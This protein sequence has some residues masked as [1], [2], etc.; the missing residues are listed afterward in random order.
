MAYSIRF[1]TDM[2]KDSTGNPKVKNV[3]IRFSFTGDGI[4]IMSTTG[5]KLDNINQWSKIGRNYKASVAN[6]SA[7]NKSLEDFAKS[8]EKI[9]LDAKK[10]GI[11]FNLEYLRTALIEKQQQKEAETSPESFY[12]L[13]DRFVTEQ[14]IKNSWAI[15]TIN[16]WSVLKNKF[17]EFESRQKKNYKIEIS[18]IDEDFLQTYLEF[19]LEKNLKNSYIK[20]TLKLTF[21]FFNWCRTKGIEFPYDYSQFKFRGKTPKAGTNIR[22]LTMEQLLSLYR[23]PIQNI[24]LSQVRDVFCFSCFTGLRYSDLKNLKKADISENKE[25]IKLITIKTSE[26]LLI[27][28]VK[29]AREILSNYENTFSK[30]ALPVCY[31]IKYNNLLRELGKLAE[32]NEEIPSVNFS[33][34][35]RIES[36][37]KKWE[38]LTS[39]VGRQTFITNAIFLGMPGEVV[40]DLTGQ[41]SDEMLRI[42]YKILDKQK[43][44]EMAKFEQYD[45]NISNGA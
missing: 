31:Q 14:K 23:M 17:I 40:K 43:L 39:H 21:W 41:S 35:K 7:K 26:P 10:A 37:F 38:R 29:F 25:F 45:N 12:D 15:G 28:L 5:Q 20:K 4:R 22:P 44:S 34:N 6:A 42:Y 33:G 1:Y 13:F 24:E 8:I 9:Y 18:K 11:K 36:T 27:P 30:L 16:L 3:P 32:F 19:L 2:R